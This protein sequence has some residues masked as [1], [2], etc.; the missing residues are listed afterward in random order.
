MMTACIR[1]LSL[2]L[3]L[4]CYTSPSASSQE[5]RHD[6]Q[7]DWRGVCCRSEG[8]CIYADSKSCSVR[9]KNDS[10]CSDGKKCSFH[11]YKGLC[12]TPP[13][14]FEPKPF[15][16]SD[17]DVPTIPDLD[18]ITPIES[19][20]DGTDREWDG[21]DTDSS[22]YSTMSWLIILAVFLKVIFWLVYMKRRYGRK[23]LRLQT[24]TL[25]S[26]SPTG[27]PNGRE[28]TTTSDTSRVEMQ[29]G[30]AYLNVVEVEEAS[31]PLPP[32]ALPPYGRSNYK[33]EQRHVVE[34]QPESAVSSCGAVVFG[35]EE[36]SPPMPS[37]A[38]PP[39]SSLEFKRQGNENNEK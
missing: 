13:T 16:L 25:I 32:N 14:T 39:Y 20:W 12:I 23:Y 15:T 34:I 1:W 17:I 21:S 22:S 38:P 3:A 9:C 29:P 10:D 26:V 31:L 33:D 2:G 24:A 28:T 37:V 36:V 6:W 4:I 19:E 18:P 30:S 5:C 27:V 8:V 35:A 7:C 11:G